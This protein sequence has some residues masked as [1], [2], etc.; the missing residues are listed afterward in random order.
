[1]VLSLGKFYLNQPLGN[2]IE[3][4]VLFAT[5]IALIFEFDKDNNTATADT[6]K[7]V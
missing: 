6:P 7:S 1:M 2:R 4:Y 5:A 3:K